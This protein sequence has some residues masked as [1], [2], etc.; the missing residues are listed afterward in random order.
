MLERYLK[1]SLTRCLGYVIVKDVGEGRLLILSILLLYLLQ[2]TEEP[3]REYFI[4]LTG[5]G[6]SSR[7]V[8]FP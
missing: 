1:E 2:H 6:G 4:F 7:P 5:T 3:A 8:E